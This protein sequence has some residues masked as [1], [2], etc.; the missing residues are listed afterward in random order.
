MEQ[1]GVFL[2][3]LGVILP[4]T[5]AAIGVAIGQGSAGVGS[6]DGQ[7]RQ[8]LAQP[9]IQQATLVGLGVL[10]TGG[11]FSLVISMLFM[12]NVPFEPTLPLGIA[13]CGIGF[14]MGFSACMVGLFTGRVIVAAT[15]AMAR[16]PLQAKKVSSFMIL[17]QMLM[18]APVVF[19]FII[20]FLV[21]SKMVPD[22]TLAQGIQYAIGGVILGLASIGPVVGQ[23]LFATR[24]CESI[25][26]NID[27]FPRIF[28]F[29][30]VVQAIIETPIIFGLLLSLSM[31]LL[32]SGNNVPFHDFISALLGVCLAFGLGSIGAGIGSGFVASRA[33]KGMVN[34]PEQYPALFR[35]TLVCQGVIDTA[36]IYSVVIAFFLLRH[37]L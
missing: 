8:I 34:D 28:S 26:I 7:S 31:V 16:Q 21:R 20:C 25:G 14:G 35:T 17:A 12:F 10:E 24:A 30:F 36:L 3:Y 18:E 22:M 33:V 6:V 1:L 2:Y 15:A 4:T 27:L 23:S 29:A 9:P 13:M 37:C 19:S 32:V 5:L 11:V